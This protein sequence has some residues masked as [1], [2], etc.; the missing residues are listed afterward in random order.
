M[1]PELVIANARLPGHAAP[2]DVALADGRIAG[3]ARHIPSDA[4]RYEA[5]AALLTPGF[6]ECHIHLDK[7]GI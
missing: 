2:M 7:A 4:P 1:T 5:A 6:V 3:I